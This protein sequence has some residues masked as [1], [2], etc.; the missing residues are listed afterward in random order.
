MFLEAQGY[1]L[2]SNQFYQDN[3]SAM[4]LAM[5][6]RASCGQKS[7]HIDI[8]F[9]FIK[10]RLRTEHISMV[11]C[12]TE[13]MLADFFTKPLQGNLFNKFKRVILGHDHISILGLETPGPIEERVGNCE[14]TAND[15]EAANITQVST[16]GTSV[17]VQKNASTGGE[18]NEECTVS[19]KDKYTSG[20]LKSENKVESNERNEQSSHSLELIQLLERN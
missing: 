7:R 18:E 5:N 10:D 8:R 6:G 13:A 19:G 15:T 11:H 16:I 9:F 14:Q 17:Q 1:V 12:P 3:Q 20:N 2:T 4:K